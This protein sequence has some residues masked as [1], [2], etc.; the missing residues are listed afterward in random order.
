MIIFIF[1]VNRYTIVIAKESMYMY[2]K[3]S[4]LQKVLQKI[5]LY[6]LKY[7]FS[8]HRKL[9]Y[10]V[11]FH[12]LSL[13]YFFYE[14]VWLNFFS[15]SLIES[16]LSRQMNIQ[17]SKLWV[18]LNIHVPLTTFFLPFW[19][20][21]SSSSSSLEEH[22]WKIQYYCRFSCA[23]SRYFLSHAKILLKMLISNAS[24]LFDEPNQLS[25][26]TFFGFLSIAC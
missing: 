8:N 19:S 1:S 15:S 4:Q 11:L 26:S 9:M 20:S 12:L 18:G 24:G 25:Y 17:N 14:F 23:M 16:L 21:C 6:Y 3:N 10:L 5:F 22:I 7:H 13:K 2:Y